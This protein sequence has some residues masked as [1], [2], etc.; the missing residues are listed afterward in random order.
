M[1]KIVVYQVDD[2]TCLYVNGVDQMQ[3]HSIDIDHLES[4]CPIESIEVIWADAD[5]EEWVME[6]G[7]FPTT[8]KET[9]QLDGRV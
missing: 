5:L 7:Y 8:L 2:W 6:N 1:N 9:L 3:N 4:H